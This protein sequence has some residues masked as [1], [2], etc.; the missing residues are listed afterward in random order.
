MTF[1]RLIRAKHYIKNTLVFMAL[2]CGGELFNASKLQSS[3]V[4]FT[5]FCL[6]S[7]ASYMVNDIRDLENDRR[8]P[9]KRG[10]PV[11]S[12]AVSVKG[13]AF[14][15][16]CMF[17]AGIAINVFMLRP[18]TVAYPVIYTAVNAA[19]SLGLKEQPIADVAILAAGFAVRLF[20][21]GSITGI[22]ISNWLFLTVLVFA[23]YFALGKRR[24]EIGMSKRGE[25]RSVLKYYTAEF[26]DKTM[27]MNLALGNAFYA[28]WS[29]D[30]N[31]AKH[32]NGRYMVYTMPVILIITMRYSLVIEKDSDG[33]PV[34][35][36]FH[37]RTLMI[38]SL[39]Y[40]ALMIIILYA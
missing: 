20:Y 19:Y 35:V 26:L 31:T 23:L 3:I 22:R 5:V 6:I 12:G 13:A 1:L 15:A 11:A 10:R 16:I 4:G 32:H 8:H 7:S 30:Y 29:I 17:T 9:V 27:Y 33:D 25:T 24:N 36:L 38:L 28:L 37:D 18:E 39:I 21:G 40:T 14:T 34:E 2:L